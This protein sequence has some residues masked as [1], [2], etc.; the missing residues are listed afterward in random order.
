MRSLAGKNFHFLVLAIA[1]SALFDGACARLG[2]SKE[3]DGE[4]T[5]TITTPLPPTQLPDSVH[6]AFGNPSRATTEA[7]D[8]DNVLVVG[9]GSV[10]SFNNSRGTVNWV[11]WKTT[12]A[13]LGRSIPRPDFQPDP[14]LPNGLK[15]IQYYHY[16]GSAYNRG[17][18]VPSADRF[19]NTELNEETFMMTN[20]VPQTGALNQYPWRNLESYARSLAWKGRD[21]YQIAGAYGQIEVLKNKVAVPTN[22]CKV[23][24]ITPRGIKI[25]N[26]GR[27]LRIIAVDMPNIEGIER[28]N[29]RDYIVSIRTIET[30]TGYDLFSNLPVEYQESFE[31]TVEMQ[32][33]VH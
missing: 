2:D 14:R 15:R 29:W 4:P 22:C 23:I 31:T 7:T 8:R 32:S 30:R 11:S 1:L 17:H 16:S 3:S 27:R 12:K 33:T 18:L 10:F 25:E 26:A 19:A 28:A 9:R 13:D 20:I 24:A 6:L 21:V 5:G